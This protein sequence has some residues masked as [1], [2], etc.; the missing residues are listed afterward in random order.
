MNAIKFWNRMRL[1]SRLSISFSVL[2][3]LAIMASGVVYYSQTVHQLKQQTLQLMDSNVNQMSRTVNLYI[4]DLERFSISIFTDPTVQSVLRNSDGANDPLAPNRIRSQLLNLSTTWSV[5]RSID[6]YALDGTLYN[7]AMTSSGKEQKLA[8]EPW[9]GKIRNYDSRSYFL[10]PTCIAPSLSQDK[11]WV[12]SLIRNIYDIPTGS[13]TGYLKIDID[14]R[15]MEK[16]LVFEEPITPLSRTE[17]APLLYI[18]DDSKNVIYDNGGG[19]TGSTLAEAGL[20]NQFYGAGGSGEVTVEGIRYL[21]AYKKSNETNWSTIVLIP[22]G[23]ILEQARH[24][25]LYILGLICSAGLL[26]VF[27]SYFISAGITR[28]LRK[29]VGLMHRV[30][31]GNFKERIPLGEPSNEIGQLGIVFNKMLDS[32]DRLIKQAYESQLQTKNAQLLALQ[33]QINPHFL[34]NTL[35][36]IKAMAK[37]KG[38]PEAGKLAEALADMF[39]YSLSNWSRPATLRMELHH[40]K[41]VLDIQLVRFGGRF[42]YELDVPDDLLE[43]PIPKLLIQPLVENAIVH[44]IEKLRSGGFIR[45]EA[46]KGQDKVLLSVSDNGKGIDPQRAEFLRRLLNDPPPT[47]H[48]NEQDGIGLVNLARRIKLC[49]GDSA[50]IELKSKPKHETKFVLHLPITD[51]YL[52]GAEE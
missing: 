8:E 10:W 27:V 31:R 41:N 19:L 4:E 25:G 39:R 9:Y 30:E 42:T 12:F 3:T 34:Y 24:S 33:T 43:K 15:V 52:E 13:K 50:S 11:K 32:I 38:A 29:M 17:A 20:S 37:R 22:L 36:T 44:G 40:V 21:Y 51:E 49:F 2:M 47:L 23:T 45:I 6:I 14:V 48:R 46:H 35:N 26:V 5:V 16:L 1:H 7:F 28:P 18:A